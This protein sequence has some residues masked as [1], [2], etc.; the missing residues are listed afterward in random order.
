MNP[1][2]YSLLIQYNKKKHPCC[3]RTTT[4]G[5]VPSAYL[6]KEEVWL[7]RLTDSC[8]EESDLLIRRI[9][10]SFNLYITIEFLTYQILMLLMSS[11]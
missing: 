3:D 9:S 7:G 5:L 8:I 6:P 11:R 1:D 10:M 4:G 2:L